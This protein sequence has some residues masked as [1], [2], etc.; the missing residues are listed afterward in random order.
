[1]DFEKKVAD[2]ASGLFTSGWAEKQ[3]AESIKESVKKAINDQ[4]S[5]GGVGYKKIRQVVEESVEKSVSRFEPEY[6]PK[7]EIVLAE[8]IK[9]TVVEEKKA[10]LENFRTLMTDSDIPEQRSSS[11]KRCVGL[12]DIFEVY[13]KYVA[14]N[15]DTE[16]R[17]VDTD[18]EPTYEPVECKAWL[19]PER[20]DRGYFRSNYKHA[21]LYLVTE[22]GQDE[23]GESC[24]FKVPLV[25]WDGNDEWTIS[26]LPSIDFARLAYEDPMLVYLYKLKHG[27]VK[28]KDTHDE[29]DEEVELEER[30]EC[31]WS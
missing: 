16:E 9:Q 14:K 11:G 13:R 10:L 21:T 23:H 28:I 7:L 8:I 3:V 25:M 5:Y 19:E 4:F 31:D 27:Y 26:E 12:A 22:D 6:I 1:M 2:I 18:D 17:K 29:F 15:F 24:N 20:E 30:P